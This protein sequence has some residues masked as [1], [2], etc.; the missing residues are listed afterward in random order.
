MSGTGSPVLRIQA[1]GLQVAIIAASWHEQVMD[2][3]IAGAVRAC[4]AAGAVA[5]VYRVPGSFE[6]PVVTAACARSGQ[7]DALVALGVVIRGGTPHFEF[8]CRAATDGL[9]RVAVDHG[10]PIGFGLLTCDT[11]AQALDRCGLPDSKE[12]KG[13]EAA[14]AALMVALTLREVASPA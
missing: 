13:A 5:S 1:E 11:E 4:G 6:L 10:L 12:D 9:S 8:V 14:N 7:F 2:G 3:L